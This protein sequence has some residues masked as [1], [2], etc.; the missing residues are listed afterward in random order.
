MNKRF[1][2]TNNRRKPT[3]AMQCLQ[4]WAQESIKKLARI[5]AEIKSRAAT[6]QP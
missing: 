1:H 6:K 3:K 4:Q 2:R 5:E